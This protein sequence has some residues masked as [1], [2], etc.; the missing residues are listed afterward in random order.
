MMMLICRVSG[1]PISPYKDGSYLKLFVNN[2]RQEYFALYLS[3]VSLNSSLNCMVIVQMY[4]CTDV[5]MYRC[6]DVQITF[7]QHQIHMNHESLIS[8]K[9]LFIDRTQIKWAVLYVPALGVSVRQ[10]TS[11][12]ITHVFSLS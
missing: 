4:R 9:N 3:L 12:I 10:A 7:Q 6:T 5:Q 2:L 1:K 11:I 8:R